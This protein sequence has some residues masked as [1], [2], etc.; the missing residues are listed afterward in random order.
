MA[1]FYLEPV[2]RLI[3]VFAPFP[4]AAL[5]LYKLLV[6][7]VALSAM[8]SGLN[9]R[10][11]LPPFAL[12]LVASTLADV[13]TLNFFFLVTDK[14][15]WLEIG[16]SSTSCPC[17]VHVRTL[18]RMPS[19]ALCDLLAVVSLQYLSILARRARCRGYTSVVDCGIAAPWVSSSVASL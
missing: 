18:T 2:Y 6:P 7:F 3:P 17:A 12:F 1:Q 10:L 4:M 15:S 14:G 16:S 11:Q 9:R 5:L 8:F 13:L 19:L